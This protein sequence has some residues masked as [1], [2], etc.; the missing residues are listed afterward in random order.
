MIKASWKIKVQTKH[1]PNHLFL[2]EHQKISMKFDYKFSHFDKSTLTTQLLAE[3]KLQIVQK[4][5]I[6][7]S[8][9]QLLDATQN[10]HIL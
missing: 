4:A 5:E 9:I 10:Q 3:V 7:L 2:D 8:L 6:D 1:H